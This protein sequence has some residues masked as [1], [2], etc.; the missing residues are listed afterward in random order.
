MSDSLLYHRMEIE[1]DY[2]R[3][4][5]FCGGKATCV[6]SDGDWTIGCVDDECTVYCVVGPYSTMDEALRAWNDRKADGH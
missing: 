5:P 4:C 3:S 1:L 6:D 2:I